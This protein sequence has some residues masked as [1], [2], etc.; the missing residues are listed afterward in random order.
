MKAQVLT[1]TNIRGGC[2]KTTN[3][4]HLAVAAA[5]E[6][7]RVLLVDLDP[8]AH[9]TRGMAKSIDPSFRGYVDQVVLGDKAG[10][11]DTAIEGLSLLPGR[12]DT[13]ML[14]GSK[15]FQK[16]SWPHLLRMGLKPLM[17]D[18]DFI[19]IDTPATFS[20]IHTL[21][22][23]ASDYYILSLR[24]EAYSFVGFGDSQEQILATKRELL[25]LEK[26]GARKVS[27]KE[28]WKAKPQFLAFILSAVN[29]GKRIGVRT[30][31][32]GLKEDERRVIEIPESS[33]FDNVRWWDTPT[34][35][36]FDKKAGAPLQK[37]YRDALNTLEGW[38]K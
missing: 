8:Q 38:M 13:N 21:A 6:G 14:Q 26:R 19:F 7:R 32:E 30:M 4:T 33:L 3:A 36:V 15:A 5:Q 34:N 16:P 10:L 31:K 29:K 35:T 37:V 17:E 9:A 23:V 1:I 27:D 11:L 28:V 24:P 18:F 25:Q 2:A 12:M 20:Q 22:F